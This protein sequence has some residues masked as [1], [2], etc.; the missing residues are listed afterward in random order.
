MFIAT[1]NGDIAVSESLKSR[2]SATV[3]MLLHRIICIK[4]DAFTNSV[5]VRVCIQFIRFR[6]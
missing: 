5:S 2:R 6:I 4:P 1:R 3:N